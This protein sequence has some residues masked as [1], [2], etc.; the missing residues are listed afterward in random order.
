LKVFDVKTE[1][2][3]GGDDLEPD[4]EDFAEDLP[5]RSA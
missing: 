3:G 1:K 4:A 5:M 2:E